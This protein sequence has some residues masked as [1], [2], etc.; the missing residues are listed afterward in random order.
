[1]DWGIHRLD[2]PQRTLQ[3]PLTGKDHLV[4]G[5]SLLAV[6]LRQDGTIFSLTPNLSQ[7]SPRRVSVSPRHRVPAS[8]RPGSRCAAGPL[9][10]KVNGPRPKPNDW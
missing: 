7:G 1:M 3:L 4:S 10:G 5:G 2:T 8:P 6:S 9:R